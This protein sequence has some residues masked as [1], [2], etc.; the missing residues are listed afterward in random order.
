MSTSSSDIAFTAAVKAIQAQKGSRT[1]YARMESQGG[2]QTKVSPDLAGFLAGLD[3]FYLGTVNGEGQPYIQYR[4][5]PVGFLKVIDDQTLGF[6][7]FGGNRQYITL[8]NLVENPK[9]FIFLMD[10]VNRQR[11]KVWGQAEVIED[12]VELNERLRD[13]D[14]AGRVERSILFHI[15]AWD[16]NC[17][18]HIHKRYP[19]SQIAPII[20]GLQTR[21]AELEAKLARYESKR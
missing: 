19:Q 20:E 2:W 3:M 7:D 6:A 17:P 12:N 21:V 1:S 11:I 9:A 16:A 5:G 18:Q 8:G 13:P 14:Y 15:K 4:G 10:Y